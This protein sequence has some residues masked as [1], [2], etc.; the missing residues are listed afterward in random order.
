MKRSTLTATNDFSSRNCAKEPERRTI[1]I[2]I[3]YAAAIYVDPI[4]GFCLLRLVAGGIVITNDFSQPRWILRMA[5]TSA[6]LLERLKKAPINSPDWTVLQDIYLPL[7]R[8]WLTRISGTRDEID[9]LAQEVLVILVRE[10]PRFTTRGN[11]SFRAWLRVIAVNQAR[12]FF[13][14]RKR[15]PL[16]GQGEDFL[17]QLEDPN[18][19][20]T[21][22]WNLDHDRHVSLKLL[23]MVKCDF[24]PTTWDAFSR[25]ALDGKPAAAVGREL[26]I[27]EN[28]VVLAKSRVL[29]RLRREARE[30]LA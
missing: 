20:L 9:D 3:R 18:S 8:F 30:F 27:S 17:S 22:E 5:S 25:F 28:A 21:R 23:Q 7:I 4:R 2:R 16:V 11:G 6:S 29:N 15:R 24:E 10:L 13:K 26:G 1:A 14:R 19:D 12:A